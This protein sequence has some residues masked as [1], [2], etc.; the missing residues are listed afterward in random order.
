MAKRR[1]PSW[2][3]GPCKNFRPSSVLEAIVLNDDFGLGMSHINGRVLV[4]EGVEDLPSLAAWA[5]P[6]ASRDAAQDT[7]LPLATFREVCP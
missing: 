2:E 5:S 6:R 7:D 4:Q 3:A 1:K